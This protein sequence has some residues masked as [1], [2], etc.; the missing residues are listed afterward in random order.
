M[1]TYSTDT[2]SSYW[3]KS[4]SINADVTQGGWESRSVSEVD[5][6]IHVYELCI[7]YRDLRGA[8]GRDDVDVVVQINETVREWDLE[9]QERL[10]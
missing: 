4:W 3:N 2:A 7:V 5:M 10:L 9:K 8:Q 1:S 6:F